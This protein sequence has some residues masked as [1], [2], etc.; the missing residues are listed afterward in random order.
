MAVDEMESL[1]RKDESGRRK[2]ENAIG[3]ESGL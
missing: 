2:Y 1:K 3:E